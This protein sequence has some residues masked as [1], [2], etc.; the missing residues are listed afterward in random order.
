MHAPKKAM[1]EK[2]RYCI[3]SHTHWDREWYIPLENFRMRL[4]DLID[5]LLDILEK[6]EG[7]RFH[8]DAQTIVLEDYL[9]IRPHKKEILEKYIQEG[10]ILV[11]PWYV[12]NDFHLTSGEAT[13]RNLMIGTG[14]ANRF[15]KCMPVGYAADQF[16]LIPQLPQILSRFG[17]DC[18][19][20][21]RGFDRNDTQFYWQSEDGSKVLCEHMKFWYNNA[22]RFSADPN[23]A[24]ALARGRGELCA[25]FAKTTNYLLMNGV[26]HLEAQEDLTE[27]IEKVRPMLN[28][29][30]E[31]FQDTM[32]EYIQRLRDDVKKNGIELNT[33]TGEFRDRGADNCLTGTLSSRVYLKT[34]NATCQS[35]LER[36]FEPLWALNDMTG[37]KKFPLDYDRYM[38]K[39]L[40]QNHPHDSICGCSVDP[41]HRHMVDRFERVMENA[42]DLIERGSKALMEH[43]DRTGLDDK[44]NYL[45][46]VLNSVQNAEKGV[47]RAIVEIPV[48][49]DT[50]SFTIRDAKGRD[51]P[52]IVTMIQKNWSKAILSPINL[53]GGR[54][55]NRYTIKLI[56]GTVAGTSYKTLIVTL[57]EGE[58][59][60]E[61]NRKKLASKLENENL[62]VDIA[63][64][65]TIT[66]TDKKSGASYPG[67]LLLE[68]NEERGDEYNFRE[69]DGTPII[70][71]ENVKAKVSVVE[72]NFFTQSRKIE[73]DFRIEREIGSGTLPVELILTLDRGSK[74]LDVQMRFTN[75]AKNHRLR[76]HFPTGLKSDVNFSGQP[77]DCIERNKVSIFNNDK[78]HPNT[79]F[80]GIEDGKRG[81]AV[82]QNGLYEYEQLTDEKNTLALTVLRVNQ[83]VSGGYEGLETMDQ[84][85]VAPENQCIGREIVHHL[86]VYPFEG[87]RETAKVAALAQ[88]FM[89]PLYTVTQPVDRN[90]FIG[91]RPFVQGPGMPDIFYRPLENADVV[92]PL[93]KTFLKTEQSID[94]AMILS[95]FKGGDDGE[96]I[97]VRWYNH[98]SK[99]VDFTA[100]IGERFKKAFAVSL[101]E[102]KLNELTLKAGKTVSLHAGPKEI[103]TVKFVK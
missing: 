44:N 12:Q 98:T 84:R 60:V 80:F 101:G 22:Q 56:P 75:Y 2:K 5:N 41:V 95:A 15:G 31:I 7:Y 99:P 8:L 52:F 49:E 67:L 58:L 64:N 55:V 18:C 87:D 94:G 83:I 68:D 57:T 77:F 34:A 20:F 53:P 103:V 59:K 102:E 71:S 3:I 73:Y 33:Y 70:T 100:T 96:G 47:V 90:K 93:D 43:L 32:P 14:I 26:D 37:V 85:W 4:V 69:N 76:L 66:L 48:E 30:E 88:S 23:G 11:G 91:G 40:I 92:L 61:E 25:R 45:I 38:W 28:D 50:G 46:T 63:K 29:D 1:S 10:R 36:K 35:T 78:R 54:R 82:F 65:G 24:L 9:E 97:V 17:L 39:V 19:I 6:D 79:D 81:L 51:I 74:Q 13:V 42:N 86:A 16:G 62:R 27:I 21:G 72:D 89:Q